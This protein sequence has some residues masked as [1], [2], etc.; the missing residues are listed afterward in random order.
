MKISSYSRALI[1]ASISIVV[2][3]LAMMAFENSLSGAVPAQYLKDG[4]LSETQKQS[5]TITLDLVKLLM[6]WAVAVIGAAGFFLKISVEKG[7]PIRA[8]DLV[9]TFCIMVLAVISLFL[10][11][12]V[13]DKS[14]LL[15]SLDQFPVNSAVIRQLGRYQ[16]IVGLSAISL[17]A[18]HVFQFVWARKTDT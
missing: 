17:F 13:I 16:F 1:F 9:L 10:G 12:L 11:H 3:V 15:L 8:R 5:I 18:F 2:I 14:A 6:N 7:V 4:S